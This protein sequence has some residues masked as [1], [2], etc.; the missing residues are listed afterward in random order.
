MGFCSDL[1]YKCARKNLKLV[2]LPVPEII[3]DCPIF[4]G[5]PRD[6]LRNGKSYGFQIWPVHSDGP[7]EQK[8]VKHF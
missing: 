1:A 5:T 7:S 8:A 6:Y 4:V 3:G 2:T